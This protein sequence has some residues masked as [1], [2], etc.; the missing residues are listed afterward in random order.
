MISMLDLGVANDAGSGRVLFMEKVVDALANQPIPHFSI[1]FI[2]REPT[3]C[4][5]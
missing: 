2:E 1:D 3:D 5:T 4:R